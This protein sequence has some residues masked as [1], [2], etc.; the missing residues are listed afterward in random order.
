MEDIYEVDENRR[1][2]GYDRV[3]CEREEWACAYGVCTHVVVVC[4][5]HPQTPLALGRGRGRLGVA[6]IV[7]NILEGMAALPLALATSKVPLH[8]IIRG[9]VVPGTNEVDTLD[10]GV[11]LT[12]EGGNK[13]SAQEPCSFSSSSKKVTGASQ[14]GNDGGKGPDNQARGQGVHK[15]VSVTGVKDAGGAGSA[16]KPH[17]Q[18]WGNRPGRIRA[19]Q[20]S[21]AQ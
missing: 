10:R 11:C 19:G 15:K 18:A 1:G 3:V 4:V 20:V 8:W 21:K 16:G 17:V 6:I 12:A 2:S 14:R 7:H 13:L 9:E 5:V